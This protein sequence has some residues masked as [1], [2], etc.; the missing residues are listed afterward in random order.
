MEAK[1]KIGNT[2]Y[3]ASALGFGCAA[4]GGYDYGPVDSKNSL[5]AINEAW[6]SGINFFDISDIYGFGTAESILASGLGANCKNAII[7]T[8]FGL[9]QDNLGAVVRDCSPEWLEEALHASLRR[10]NIDHIPIYLIHWYDEKTQLDELVNA[11][12]N[13][14]A[15]GKIGKFGVC[16]F[17]Q[18]Q[19]HE[20]CSLGGDN[21]LQLPFSLVDT[22]FSASLKEASKHKNSLTMAYDVLG[23]GIL[24]GKYTNSST[25]S[26]TDTRSGHKYFE[27]ESLIKNL[28]LVEK[29]E[30][31][32]SNHGV[33]SAQV[34]IRWVI[35][36]GFVDV[37][38]VG[39]KTPEQVLANVDI[40]NFDMTDADMKVLS[41]LANH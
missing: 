30:G 40:F 35:N 4:I 26:G 29:L 9:R 19:Y 34:A 41:E 12:N 39:C 11:L 31:I 23:R 33:S 21:S 3:K 7:A 32:A 37:T 28:K 5:N 27:G 16:N 17:S 36:M 1:K 18:S 25:F 24:T 2:N 38:L 14:K 13:Y 8:K 10:L 15:Q 6:N 22:S 20:F